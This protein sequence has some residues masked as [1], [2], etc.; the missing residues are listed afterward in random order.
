MV[1]VESI[2]GT[3]MAKQV[4]S[5]LGSFGLI[6]KVIAFVKDK[7]TNLGTMTTI[8]FKFFFVAPLNLP[9]P[10]FGTC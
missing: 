5:F 6:N 9:T 1:I 10:F 2:I 3:T 4:K 8:F 7:R